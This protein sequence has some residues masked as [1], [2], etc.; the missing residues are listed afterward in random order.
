LGRPTGWQQLGGWDWAD[1]KGARAPAGRVSRAPAGRVS[2]APAGRVSRE[3][4][5]RVSRES[6]GRCYKTDQYLRG[7]ITEDGRLAIKGLGVVF[8]TERSLVAAMGAIRDV[9]ARSICSDVE[10][11]YDTTSDTIFLTLSCDDDAESIRL[12]MNHLQT[13]VQS[14]PKPFEDEVQEQ[15]SESFGEVSSVESPHTPSR[16]HSKQSRTSVKEPENN[17]VRVWQRSK[18]SREPVNN[19]VREPVNNEVRER[20]YPVSTKYSGYKAGTY[21]GP[22]NPGKGKPLKH[23]DRWRGGGQ[24][25]TSLNLIHPC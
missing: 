24:S 7:I 1:I 14:P 15:M 12:F 8:T 2:R 6:A 16:P 13:S 17:D 19:E 22:R 20:G 4:A 11:D 9:A 5:G 21:G 3:P 25:L 18:Q 23:L 10:L